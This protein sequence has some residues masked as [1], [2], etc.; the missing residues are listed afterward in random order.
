MKYLKFLS[1]LIL[2][3][4]L[5]LTYSCEKDPN[6]DPNNNDTT[7]VEAF[8]EIDGVTYSEFNPFIQTLGIIDTNGTYGHWLMFTSKDI[9][10]TVTDNDVVDYDGDGYVLIIAI[11]TDVW[12]GLPEGTIPFNTSDKYPLSTYGASY[13][14]MGGGGFITIESGD[15][16]I[17]KNNNEYEIEFELTDENA[18][19][20]AAY[21]KGEID[22]HYNR[23]A[24]F[25]DERDEQLYNLVKIGDQVWF[26]RNYAYQAESDC[27]LM[28][29]EDATVD[30][31]GYLYTWDKAVELT[32]EGF[33]LPTE[34]DFFELDD[35][36]DDNY[37]GSDNDEALLIEGETNFDAYQYGYAYSSESFQTRNIAFF[38]T[39]TESSDT[40]VRAY[41]IG[42]W[43]NMSQYY[44][45][46]I[47]YTAPAQ[48]TQG[49]SIRFIKE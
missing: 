33:R 35:Y 15:I 28:D 4:F 8:F 18:E 24:Y 21:Y 1:L 7:E 10:L 49:L 17:T 32:P 13:F 47:R 11:Y 14:K 37:S 40:E 3:I 31:Y 29:D 26:Q 46:Y 22:F 23:E 6:T 9:T 41:G 25:Y 19:T 45:P 30:K 27:W 5:T 39:S 16:S 38:W 34:D 20:V 48:K 43:D 44:D 36:V 2:S 42:M 12:G